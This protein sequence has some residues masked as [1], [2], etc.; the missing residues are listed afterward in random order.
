MFTLSIYEVLSARVHESSV[1]FSIVWI[2]TSI[3]L[4]V[5]IKFVC[6]CFT[7]HEKLSLCRSRWNIGV[8]GQWVVI[9]EGSG[10]GGNKTWKFSCQGI[11]QCYTTTCSFLTKAWL[12]YIVLLAGH[13][14]YQ[15]VIKHLERKNSKLQS[16]CNI[17]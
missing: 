11:K 9:K 16:T 10:Q 5:C 15:N 12:L 13:N 6:L 17:S 7:F 3:W 2:N 8:N 1:S 4:L 14:F